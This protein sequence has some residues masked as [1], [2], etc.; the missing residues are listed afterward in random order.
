MTEDALTPDE[1][2]EPIA[3]EEDDTQPAVSEPTKLIRIA[4][5]TRAMLEEVRQAPLDIESR[6]RLL[7]VHRASISELREVL[8]DELKDELD[9]IFRPFDAEHTPTEGE[10][11]IAHAQLI[12]W[13][14]GL[15]HGIQASIMT[16]QMMMQTQLAEMSRRQQLEPGQEDPKKYPGVYL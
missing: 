14:E 15:F 16:Q 13:L 11:R 8:S 1:I 7:D 3:T 2:S 6:R 4:S 10:L 9:E 12:G 5:M